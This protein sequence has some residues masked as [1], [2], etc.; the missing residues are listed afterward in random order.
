MIIC[1][2]CGLSLEAV[3]DDAEQEYPATVLQLVSGNSMFELLSGNS[4][5]LSCH[6]D[7]YVV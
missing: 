4:K 5:L 6:I 1:V 2:N 3:C 7:V